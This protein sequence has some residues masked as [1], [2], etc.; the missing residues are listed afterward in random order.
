M[1][2]L[3][4]AQEI[5]TL[6]SELGVDWRNQPA[7]NIVEFCLGKIGQ[8][9]KESGP[10]TSIAELEKLAC[11][12][13]SLVFEEVWNDEDLD[14]IIRKYVKAGEPVFASLKMDLDEKTYATLLERHNITHNAQDRYVAVID[15]RGEKALRRFFTRWHEIAHLLTLVRQLELPFHRSRDDDSPLER[16]MDAVAGEV[17]FYKPIF[18]P[19]LNEVL[20]TCDR[21]SFQMAELIRA[22]YSSEA[23][24]QSTLF[25]AIRGM[26]TP[27]IYLEAGMGFKKEEE[28]TL[29]SSQLNLLPMAPP[30][31]KLRVITVMQN[32]AAKERRFRIDRNM[33]VPPKS[34]IAAYFENSNLSPAEGVEELSGWLHSNGKPVGQGEVH[35]EARFHAGRVMAIVQP[36]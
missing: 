15:C 6:A 34:L 2:R 18:V 19:V 27:I 9:I 29:Q 25:A 11:K 36:A 3:N 35:I 32:E 22:R 21:F 14:Q 10:V 31:A 8:W 23:S 4:S 1:T 17:G 26:P 20:R 12:R 7:Q 28:A 5:I 24:F 33:A 16:M 13:L 30:A